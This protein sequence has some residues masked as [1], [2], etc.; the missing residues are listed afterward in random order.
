M[1]RGASAW[2]EGCGQFGGQAKRCVRWGIGPSRDVLDRPYTAGGGGSSPTPP[3]LPF[4]CWRRTANILLRRLQCQEDLSFRIVGPPSVGTTGGAPEEGG[5]PAKPP[6]LPWAHPCI[7]GTTAGGHMLPQPSPRLGGRLSPTPTKLCAET[8]SL[9]S[10]PM[11][12]ADTEGVP[13]SGTQHRVPGIGISRAWHC[14][15]GCVGCVCV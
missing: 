14:W 8:V 2:H 1:A 4:Q 15:W 10:A 5:V 11:D 7:R 12:V 3:L 6:L 13:G 9:S